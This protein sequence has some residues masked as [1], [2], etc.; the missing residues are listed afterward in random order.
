[1]S[2][3]EL[4]CA[5]FFYPPSVIMD[6]L[7]WMDAEWVVAIQSTPQLGLS[8]RQN[9][10]KLNRIT[11]GCT[12]CPRTISAFR[13]LL[14]ALLIRRD[15]IKLSSKYRP[16]AWRWRKLGFVWYKSKTLKIPVE[17][18]KGVWWRFL[19][20]VMNLGFEDPN[21]NRRSPWWGWW[22]ILFFTCLT[23]ELSTFFLPL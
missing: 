19:Q 2:G 22:G 6:T 14:A 15:S 8:L 12:V 16:S 10:V 4:F 5:L 21:Q 9:M 18:W 20:L 3:G 23:C 11:F 13:K 1:M 17:M 7:D